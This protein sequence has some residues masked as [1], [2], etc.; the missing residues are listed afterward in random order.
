MVRKFKFFHGIVGPRLTAVW[1]PQLQ[2]DLQA[3]H[4]LDIESELTR[5]MSEEIA[6]EVDN[7]I[8]SELTRR[9]NGGDLNLQERVDYF[10]RW[11][12]VGGGQRA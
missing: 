4:G 7:N 11:L 8:I 1:S 2:E 10:E 12:D 6:R 9:I 5:L 3:G